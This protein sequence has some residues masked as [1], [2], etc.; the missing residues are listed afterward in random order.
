MPPRMAGRRRPLVPD[1]AG[2][3]TPVPNV[4]GRWSSRSR[5]RG[6]VAFLQLPFMSHSYYLHGELM[7][8]I[9]SNRIMIA[10]EM[11]G[12]TV[13]AATMITYHLMNTYQFRAGP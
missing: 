3:K 5:L 13:L 4:I 6:N 7:K 2:K 12:V 11:L 8:S 1:R 9:F 10:A